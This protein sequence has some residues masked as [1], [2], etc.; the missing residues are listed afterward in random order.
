MMRCLSLV[1]LCALAGCA[2][3]PDYRRP[4]ATL[5]E[6]WARTAEQPTPSPTELANLAWWQEFKEPP[7]TALVEEAFANNKD[8]RV[9]LARVEE[10]DGA[11]VSTRGLLFPQV[12]G[13]LS[14]QRAHQSA[15]QTASLGF[16]NGRT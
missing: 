8:L 7:L 1:A 3:G 12:G 9:A 14:G 6:V 16:P 2:V 11:F 13:N 15:A 10:A 4:Q 5:P